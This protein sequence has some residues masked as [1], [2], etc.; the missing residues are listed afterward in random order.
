MQGEVGGWERF[1]YSSPLQLRGGK[2]WIFQVWE[3]DACFSLATLRCLGTQ[4]VHK[5]SSWLHNLMDASNFN[6]ISTNSYWVVN[7]IP[8]SAL[9]GKQQRWK[10]QFLPSRG[11]SCPH[12]SECGRRAERSGDHESHRRVNKQSQDKVTSAVTTVGTGC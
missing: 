5:C 1:C 6:C 2:H 11:S 7:C 10:K 3:P 8:S 9:G 12:G 4:A